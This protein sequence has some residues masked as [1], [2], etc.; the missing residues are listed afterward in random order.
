M[1]RRGE[2]DD[3]MWILAIALI[4]I[5]AVGI[6]SYFVPYTG[7]LT[8]ITVS[9]FSPGEVGYVQDFVA[10]ST[11]LQTFTVG[12]EQTETLKAYPQIEMATSLFGGN[13]EKAMIEV[14]DYLLETAR[15][16]SLDFFIYDTN[17]Y[18]NLVVKWNGREIMNQNLGNGPQEMF[19]EKEHVRG[20]NSLEVSVTGPGLFFWASSVYIIKNFNVNLDYGP[21]RIIPFEMLSSEM[22][23]FEKIELSSYA[24]GT[25]TL[26]IKV[27]GVQVFSGTPNGLMREDFTLFEAPVRPG[28]NILTL[29]DQT[30]TY[31]L[32]DTVFKVFITGDQSVARHRFNMSDENYNFLANSIFHGKVDYYIENIARPGRV[33]I[34]VNGR[35]LG[36]STPRPGW[37]SAAFTA[38]SVQVGDNV[39]TFS[40][41][42]SFRIREAIIG[43]ER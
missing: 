36:T 22:E 18:G 14:P 3:F 10:R 35:Q 32:R 42:G 37:N 5:I 7:P 9:S 6:F 13:T 29:I 41:T 4:L 11:N 40:G 2:V 21:A 27:N 1:R 43:L 28:Q 24:S 34:E 20:S 8:N 17:R 23:K 39:I 31:T 38:D 12:E 26:V 33:E 15:G 16:V 30:G 19:I 25:G